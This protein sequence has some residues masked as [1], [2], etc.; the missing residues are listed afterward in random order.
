MAK[1]AILPS[2]PA[3]GS[4][5]GSLAGSSLTAGLLDGT[6]AWLAPAARTRV[7][8]HYETGHPGMPVLAVVT[9]SAVRLPN[10]L[11]A[12]R[13]PSDGELLVGGGQ[14]RDPTTTTWQ[15]TRWW[16]P[17]RPVGLVPAGPVP[18]FDPPRSLG[19]P[20]PAPA[21]DGLDPAALLGAGPGLT[22]AGDDV[23]A[24]A[25]V[26]A[27]ATGDPRTEDWRARTRDALAARSTTAVSRGLLHC[28]LDGYATAELAGALTALCRGGDASEPVRRLL[29]V[30]HSSGAALLAGVLHALSTQ[31]RP[32]K[33]AA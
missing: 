5:A 19:V 11:V 14:L 33:A 10:S 32:W 24:G 3:P 23:L 21:Y 16:R 4:P 12:D 31:N 18:A 1:R 29:A 8:V 13:L 7:S 9:P 25:L 17:A 22:P 30:G 28:A 6:S 26:A 27:H 20:L 2:G 15:V